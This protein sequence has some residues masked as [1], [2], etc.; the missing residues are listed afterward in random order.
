MQR[1]H[2]HT[3]PVVQPPPVPLLGYNSLLRPIQEHT[4][5]RAFLGL[6]IISRII[7]TNLGVKQ[8][9]DAENRPTDRVVQ[10]H[11]IAGT[12]KRGLATGVE[13]IVNAGFVVKTWGQTAAAA[14]PD[15]FGVLWGRVDWLRKLQ[16]RGGLVFVPLRSRFGGF[17]LVPLRSCCGWDGGVVVLKKWKWK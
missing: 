17:V 3:Q 14:A 7:H 2:R 16:G 11:T 5:P 4:G 1:Q 12:V 6:T 10:Y 13:R 15:W 9:G 8:A